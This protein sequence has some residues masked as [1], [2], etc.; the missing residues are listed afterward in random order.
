VSAKVTIVTLH[1]GVY[2]LKR[3]KADRKV[4]QES[5]TYRWLDNFTIV[6]IEHRPAQPL[7]IMFWD[8]LLGT[9]NALP[10]AR[11]QN[12]VCKPDSISYPVPA[13]A[14]HRIRWMNSFMAPEKLEL[15][16]VAG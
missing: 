2:Q 5:L 15:A 14:D 12:P 13:C 11:V 3:S 16:A 7:A 10:F 4:R 8:G 6:E 1:R 9:G